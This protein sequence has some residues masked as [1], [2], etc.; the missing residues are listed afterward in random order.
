MMG[1]IPLK[2]T[3][4]PFIDQLSSSSFSQP[5]DDG[6]NNGPSAQGN[7][8]LYPVGEHEIIYKCKY[9]LTS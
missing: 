4:E 1:R 2:R 8:G 5:E 7:A 6:F 3:I 9:S